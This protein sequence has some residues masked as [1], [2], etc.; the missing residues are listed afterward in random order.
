[1][2]QICARLVNYLPATLDGNGSRV[3]EP[4]SP[5]VHVWGAPPIVMRCGVPTPRGFD[6]ASAQV[7]R[8]DGVRWFQYIGADTVTW[9]AIRTGAN[10]EL[11]VPKSY[12]GQGGL[13]VELGRAIRQTI[14]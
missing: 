11:V 8:V 1:V 5:L 12:V 13:L 2:R 14:D 6:P 9:T 10:I 7:A 4:R 3:V